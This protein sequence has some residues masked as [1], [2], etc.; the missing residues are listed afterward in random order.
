MRIGGILEVAKRSKR[1][2]LEAAHWGGR[3]ATGF[4]GPIVLH[5]SFQAF[6]GRVGLISEIVSGSLFVTLAG[7]PSASLEMLQPSICSSAGT[8]KECDGIARAEMP[9]R[10]SFVH[11]GQLIAGQRYAVHG[12]IAEDPF[13][14]IHPGGRG[15]GEVQF[16]ALDAVSLAM[17]LVAPLDP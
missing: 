17:P 13:H 15:G 8:A 9:K 14:K 6:Q 5:G 7:N 10:G 1:T 4:S 2:S 11:Q 16:D 12:Q 3:S